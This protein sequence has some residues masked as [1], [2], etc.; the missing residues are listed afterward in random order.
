MG[1]M[2]RQLAGI[3]K[4]LV[5]LETA[6]NAPAPN[7][8][9]IIEQTSAILKVHDALIRMPS[10]PSGTPCAPGTPSSPSAEPVDVFSKGLDTL[11]TERLVHESAQQSSILFHDPAQNSGT[12][13][14][15]A[16]KKAEGREPSGIALRAA[17][18]M[19]RKV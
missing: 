7:T 8:A 10:D 16:G 11:F 1:D 14:S 17:R 12:V 15:K 4:H 2:Q 3:E 13:T 18:L 9:K 5:M 19:M 6:V